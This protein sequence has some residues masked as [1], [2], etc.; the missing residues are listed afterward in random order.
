[1]IGERSR[2]TWALL[3]VDGVLSGTYRAVRFRSTS[4]FYY[5]YIKTYSLVKYSNNYQKIY[6]DI[7]LLLKSNESAIEI[8]NTHYLK[9]MSLQVAFILMMESLKESIE[10]ID[11]QI[12]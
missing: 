8:L 12:K 5:L 10:I 9:V 2:T 7:L 1:M 11:S 3:I 6:T 4:L